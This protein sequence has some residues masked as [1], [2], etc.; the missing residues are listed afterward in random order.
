[1]LTHVDLFSGIGG[2]ALACKWNGIKTVQFVEIDPF[3]QKV[4]QKNFP[5]VS[6]HDDIKTFHWTGD[7]PF[8]LT[9]GFPCQPFSAAGKRKG[10]ED[11]RYLWPEMFR[12]ISEAKP[13]WIIG[14]NVTGFYTMGGVQEV[15]DDLEGIGFECQPFLI[16][17]CAIG[18]GFIGERIWMV[19]KAKSIGFSKRQ[20][21][22]RP[23]IESDVRMPCSF[24]ECSGLE[25]VWQEAESKLY[26]IGDGLPKT[27]DEHRMKALGNSIVPQVAAEI[28]RGIIN[29]SQASN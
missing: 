24:M 16:P 10:K 25:D 13:A 23:I 11:D 21:D 28:I 6:I 1:M 14:E 29:A 15:I 22:N 12:V 27:L 19:G 20:V 26:G 17:S 18:T 7:S 3:C 2:F 9:G 8:I 4:L 5:G